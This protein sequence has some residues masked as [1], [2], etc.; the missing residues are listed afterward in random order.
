MRTRFTVRSPWLGGVLCGMKISSPASL[1]RFLRPLT[2]RADWRPERPT[3]AAYTLS[4]PDYGAGILEGAP[5]AE[6]GGDAISSAPE[7]ARQPHFAWAKDGEVVLQVVGIG[8]SGTTP[9]NPW[10]G[11]ET[12][13]AT[14]PRDTSRDRP[15]GTRP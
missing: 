13:A 5:R 14:R 1:V 11:P 12:G 15:A 8:P 4:E 3:D 10:S 2:Q 6:T 9:T 7:P